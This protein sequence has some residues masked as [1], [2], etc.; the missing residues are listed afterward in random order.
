MNRLR[1]RVKALEETTEILRTRNVE[2]QEKMAR[3]D[4]QTGTGEAAED[5]IGMTIRGYL[6]EMENLK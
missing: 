3:A 2:L 5:A 1:T 4:G 6:E